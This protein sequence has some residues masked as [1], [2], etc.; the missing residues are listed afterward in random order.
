MKPEE[1]FL[2]AEEYYR[3]PQ[4]YSHLTRIRN[5]Q[6]EITQQ[7]LEFLSLKKESLILDI[8]CGTGI[9][10]SELA[11]EGHHWI[12]CDISIDMLKENEN[13]ENCAIALLNTDIGNG[14]PFLPASFDAAVSVS[15]IQWLF[16]NRN[17][18]EGRYHARKFFTSLRSVLKMNGKAVCQFYSIHNDHTTILI[19]ESKRAGFYSVIEQTGEGK[20][21][22]KFLT[23]D[24]AKEIKIKKQTKNKK[25]DLIK[26]KITK[27]KE[28]RL[29]KGLEV[30]RD[31]KYSGRKRAKKF[32]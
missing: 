5:V 19:E 12:G 32:K 3:K 24:C 26:R 16:H 30:S 11:N 28:K 6:R 2:P 25:I 21:I 13:D 29:R 14:L 17:L 1:Q 22:K 20:H 15:C 8:G 31:S 27:M 10:G 18:Q 9:S 23:L 4:S 7:C